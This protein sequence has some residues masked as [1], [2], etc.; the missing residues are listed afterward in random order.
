MSTNFFAE[1]ML[2]LGKSNPKFF[3]YIQIAAIALGSV[4]AAFN[5]ID[6][7]HTILPA[8]L[9]WIQSSTVMITSAVTAVVAQLP[10]KDVNE[11]LKKV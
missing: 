3:D 11:P 2:R 6:E 1:L 9:A 5:F 4:S 10:N 8:W 7:Q